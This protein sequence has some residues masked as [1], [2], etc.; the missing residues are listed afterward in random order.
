[1][2]GL[3][4][5]RGFEL[6][7][8]TVTTTLAILAKKGAGKSN[9]AV[10][11]AE[12]MFKVG[13]PWVAI[14]PKGDW[15]GMRSSADGTK[16]GLPLVVF[17]GRHGDVPLEA[18]AGEMLADLVLANRLTCILDVSEFSKAETVRFLTAFG[19]RLYRQA[20]SE[21]MHLFLEEA[22]EYLPQRVMGEDARLVGV[23]QKIVK[24][25]RFKGIGVTL[26][27]QR[28]ASLNKD[29]LTQA[30]TLIVLRTTSP[31][32][33]AAVKAWVD[34][35]DASTRMLDELPSL[36]T[37]EAWVWSPEELGVLEK[38]R[39]RQ[40]ETFDS[41]ATPKVGQ[42]RRAPA[43]LADVDLD[44]IKVAMAATIEKAKDND[45]TELRKRIRELEK[46]LKTAP[47]QR[48]EVPVEVVREVV[49]QPVLEAIDEIDRTASAQV[50]L[51]TSMKAVATALLKATKAVLVQTSRRTEPLRSVPEVKQKPLKLAP[52]PRDASLVVSNAQRRVLTVL[53]QYGEQTKNQV[54]IRAEYSSRSGSF[55]NLLSALRTAEYIT[56][57]S[58]IEITP[59]GLAALGPYEAL[60]SGDELFEL[61]CRRVGGS[62]GK[63]LRALRLDVL[64]HGDG[65]SK[66]ELADATQYSASSGSFNNLLS[67]LRTL[68]LITRGAPIA[69][70]YDFVEAIS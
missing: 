24:Q 25:G 60:P 13:V 70:H 41:G 10:V 8:D 11:L 33:R 20:T 5:A 52:P 40:R 42:A 3:R 47:T 29:V 48:V 19:D 17:G 62:A 6:P 56:R 2:S 69:L 16:P 45:P 55:N 26:V 65:M 46:Q 14:D 28:S 58:A 51:A 15:W 54:A 53:A 18:T 64:R 21:P 67:K 12:E 23:W 36:A 31:Q 61:T 66:E 35:H 63:I 4:I 49:P 1:M 57:G 22:H 39:F 50:D 34:I 59:A 30:D 43:T 7:L 44:A 27:T 9:A 37:G 68:E 32:D 38:V